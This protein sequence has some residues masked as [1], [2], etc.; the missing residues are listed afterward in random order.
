MLNSSLPSRLLY[1]LLFLASCRGDDDLIISHDALRYKVDKTDEHSLKLW[2]E[3]NPNGIAVT[4]KVNGIQTPMLFR[5][6]TEDL[7][8]AASLDIYTVMCRHH[9]LALGLTN[10]GEVDECPKLLRKEVMRIL[11]ARA[12]DRFCSGIAGDAW[13]SDEARCQAT[14]T[15]RMQEATAVLNAQTDLAANW[16]LT[17]FVDFEWASYGP[18]CEELRESAVALQ[19]GFFEGN[20]WSDARALESSVEPLAMHKANRESFV[21]AMEAVDAATAASSSWTYFE[22]GFNA[23]HSAAIVLTL[24]PRAIVLAYDLCIHA[25]TLPHYELLRRRFGEG[26]LQLTCGDSRD[27]LAAAA[28]AAAAASDSDERPALAD[29]VRVDGGHHFSVAAADV[30]NSRFMAKGG[31]PVIVDDC[32]EPEV[33]AAWQTA[34]DLGVVTAP[35][36][37]LGWK[38]SCHGRFSESR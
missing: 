34:V 36:A 9:G 21:L 7:A 31:A 20:I 29:V 6:D 5:F 4:A 30:F 27:T 35:R 10:V 17:S 32:A 37:G 18:L 25:Y 38:G 13:M 24:F 14:S 19:A 12:V 8:P 23:G 28:A 15:R 16:S 26:R 2:R 1:L 3:A 22:V 33:W 11:S